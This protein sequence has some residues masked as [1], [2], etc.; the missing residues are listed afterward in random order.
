MLITVA[1]LSEASFVSPNVQP[2]NAAIE[3]TAARV[4]KAPLS[5]ERRRQPRLPAAVSP[6]GKPFA[7]DLS[8]CKSYL[9]SE[10]LLTLSL[11]PLSKLFENLFLDSGDI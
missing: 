1:M 11:K 6:T 3:G 9:N 10:C 8:L 5:A 7:A 2:P 4:A